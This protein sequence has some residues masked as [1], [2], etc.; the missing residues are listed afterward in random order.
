VPQVSEQLEQVIMR[1]LEKKAEQRYQTMHEIEAD[2]QRV[3]AGQQPVGAN[4]VTLTPTRPP[5]PERQRVSP[6]YLG[7]L[8][9]AVLALVGTLAFGAYT[10]RRAESGTDGLTPFTAAPEAPVAEPIADAAD[11]QQVE[12]KTARPKRVRRK[13]RQHAKPSPPRDQAILD[14]WK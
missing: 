9:V 1:C 10:D 3:H 5:P 6:I 12:A 14:P 13:P 7:G 2:L 11:A 8:G 4:T